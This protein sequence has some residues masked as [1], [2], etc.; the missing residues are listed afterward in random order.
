MDYSAISK[1]PM[2]ENDADAG[3][4]G[5]YLRKLLYTLWNEGEGFNSKRPFGNSG[6]GYELYHALVMNG[7]VEGSIDPEYDELEEFD[8]ES[9]DSVIFGV[10]EEVFK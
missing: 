9:A 4:I 7:V 10:I 5:E 1:L 8:S 2:Q 6:W 3:T